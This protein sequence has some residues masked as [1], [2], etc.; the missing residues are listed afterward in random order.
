[1]TSNAR[2]K[3]IEEQL[4]YL[5]WRKLQNE[6]AV[7]AS[8]VTSRAMKQK[9]NMI[10]VARSTRDERIDFLSSVVQDE[11]TR[12]LVIEDNEMD[13]IQAEERRT[14]ERAYTREI[15]H[16]QSSSKIENTLKARLPDYDPG[17]RGRF[18]DS[19]LV[20]NDFYIG[21]SA[22]EKKAFKQRQKQLKALKRKGTSPNS[23]K[24]SI[25]SPTYLV[26]GPPSTVVPKTPS[27][28]T[29]ASSMQR[30]EHT[31]EKLGKIKELK[32]R[33]DSNVVSIKESKP[34]V[35]VRWQPPLPT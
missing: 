14:K 17:N 6:R 22:E 11:L 9:D 24:L 34:I 3:Q 13:R 20:V 7:K 27:S 16:L 4:A 31:Q 8:L 26:S 25:E 2:V 10:G 1:M 23:S 5:N 12:P 30:V 15:H 21:E 29:K 18:S 32:D 35:T 33:I 19:A 28:P